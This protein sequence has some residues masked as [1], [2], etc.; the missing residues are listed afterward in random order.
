MRVPERR[1]RDA[2]SSPSALR[3]QGRRD[4]TLGEIA[5]Q[6]RV[7]T[8]CRIAIAAAASA[9][10][11][12]P[13]ARAQGDAR[14][15]CDLCFPRA[16]EPHHKTRARTIAAAGRA[17]WRK[18]R[19]VEAADDGRVLEQLIFASGRKPAAPLSGAA[20]IR[21]QVE[22]G[23]AAGKLRFEDLDRGGVQIGEV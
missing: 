19:L 18:A 4:I 2:C 5:G 17:T 15:G 9:L 8:L 16:T 6:G 20:R 23:D 11:K 7:I 13:L 14:G 12:K 10:Q 3:D 1:D 22:A 21:N